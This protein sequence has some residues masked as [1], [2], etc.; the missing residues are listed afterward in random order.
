M[1]TKEQ[2]VVV[3]LTKNRYL[4]IISH[5]KEQLKTCY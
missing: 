1:D 3:D 2:A 5:I 4:P